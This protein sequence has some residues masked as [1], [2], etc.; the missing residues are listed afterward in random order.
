MS[1]EHPPSFLLVLD[2]NKCFLFTFQISLSDPEPQIAEFC[3]TLG[4][5]HAK[6]ISGEAVTVTLCPLKLCQGP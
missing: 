2:F 1:R 3:L 4:Y 6:Q 5:I